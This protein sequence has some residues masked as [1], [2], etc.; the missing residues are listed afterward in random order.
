MKSKPAA[1]SGRVLGRLPEP[2]E[3]DRLSEVRSALGGM[4]KA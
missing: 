4:K 3:F 1:S 2:G